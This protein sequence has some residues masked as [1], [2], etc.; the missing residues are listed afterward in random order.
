MPDLMT[1]KGLTAYWHQRCHEE[2]AAKEKAEARVKE[3]EDA[4]ACIACQKTDDEMDTM[5]VG[6]AD[7][8]GAYNQIVADARAAIKKGGA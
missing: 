3:L 4:L 1:D 7:Y 5:D 8:Q 6:H 2:C